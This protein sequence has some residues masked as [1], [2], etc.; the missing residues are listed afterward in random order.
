MA[1]GA[2]VCSSVGQWWQAAPAGAH[3]VGDAGAAPAPLHLLAWGVVATVV[4]VFA[5]SSVFWRRP[6]LERLGGGRVVMAGR[7]R[8]LDAAAVV[9]SIVVFALFVTVVVAGLI[10]TNRV[11]A[12][13]APTTVFVI[14]WV[15][16]PLASLVF[17]DVWRAVSPFETIAG[18]V[19]RVRGAPSSSRAPN[20]WLAVVALG[21]FTWLESGYHRG[22][23]PRTVGWALVVYTVWLTVGTWRGGRGWLRAAEGFGVLFTLVAALSPLYRDGD[24]RLRARPP[25]SGLAGLRLELPAVV[26]LVLVL[27]GIVFDAVK[28]ATVWADLVGF[29]SGWEAT[30]VHSLGLVVVTAAVGAVVAGV[31]V[32]VARRATRPVREVGPVFAHGLVPVVVGYLLGHYFSLLVIEGQQRFRILLSDPLGRGADLFGTATRAIDFALV[33]AT[34]VSWLQVLVIAGAHVMA[35]LV[36]HDRAL[37]RCSEL[38]VHY[39]LLMAVVVSAVVGLWASLPA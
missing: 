12:N 3:G 18:L 28:G 27:G 5:V 19:E 15:G 32:L 24:R 38:S 30:L 16:V 31:A 17:G 35:V 14:F 9:G 34:L 1:G 6:C 33:D 7:A 13:L 20:P 39:P 8:V 21:A 11:N 22:A 25:G 37:E 36:I 4:A 26:V 2:V 10:G 29:R 23:E